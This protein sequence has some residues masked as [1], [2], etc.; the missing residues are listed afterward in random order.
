LL[1]IQAA[2]VPPDVFVC[3]FR[4]SATCGEREV[5]NRENTKQQAT[6]KFSASPVARGLQLETTLSHERPAPNNLY[7]GT[8]LVQLVFGDRLLVS[9]VKKASDSGRTSYVGQAARTGVK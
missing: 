4:S 7:G 9:H 8:V 5:R 3:P 6:P 1:E 2:C